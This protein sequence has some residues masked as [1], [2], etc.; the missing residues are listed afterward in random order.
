MKK[1]WIYDSAAPPPIRLNVEDRDFTF[2]LKKKVGGRGL[3]L[4]SS[5]QGQEAGCCEDGNDRLGCIP[6][7][8]ELSASRG[9]L[10]SMESVS[11]SV[12]WWAGIAFDYSDSLQDGRSRDRIPVEARF[13]APVQTGPG[14][15]PASYTMGTDSLFRG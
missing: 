1:E 6:W 2:T 8:E 13:S 14:A 5:G 12:S 10:C 11:Q 4:C 7:G 15:H 9:G 3:G